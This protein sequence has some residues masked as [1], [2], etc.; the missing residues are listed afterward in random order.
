MKG[1]DWGTND[2]GDKIFCYHSKAS[3]TT[4]TR[5]VPEI[6]Q[7]QHCAD[8]PICSSTEVAGA[9]PLP[10]LRASIHMPWSGLL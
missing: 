4:G 10:L 9:I 6:K 5:C 3:C 2:D 7:P 8:H 1:T